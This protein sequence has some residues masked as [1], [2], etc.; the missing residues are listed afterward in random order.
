M[1]N[2][3]VEVSEFIKSTKNSFWREL[4]LFKHFLFG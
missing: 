2:A 3:V 1:D 4:K